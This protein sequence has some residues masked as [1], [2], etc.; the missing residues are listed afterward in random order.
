VADRLASINANAAK[1]VK[2]E[3]VSPACVVAWRHRPDGVHKGGGA[4]R[5]YDAA[6]RITS[7]PALPTISHGMDM[8]ALTDVLGRYAAAVPQG[9]VMNGAPLPAEAVG[10]QIRQLPTTPN[11]SLR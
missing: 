11:E 1:K 7:G 8:I 10:E 5:Y 6:S 9:F 3:T 4:E 2:A